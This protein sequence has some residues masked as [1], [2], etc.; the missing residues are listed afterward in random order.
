M[1]ESD[2]GPRR[3]S[4]ARSNLSPVYPAT[5]LIDRSGSPTLMVNGR[6]PHIENAFLFHR[7]GAGSEPRLHSYMMP[8]AR[9]T[10]LK[11]EQEFRHVEKRLLNIEQNLSKMETTLTRALEEILQSLRL[12]EGSAPGLNRTTN[13]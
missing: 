5:E 11:Y 4:N 13:V 6:I 8:S 10:Q 1:S 2:L 9:S 12:R 7:E 3:L